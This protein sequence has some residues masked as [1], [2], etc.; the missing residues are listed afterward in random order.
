MCNQCGAC[1]SGLFTCMSMEEIQR[2]AYGYERWF[3]RRYWHEIPDEEG[4]RLAPWVASEAVTFF[5]CD[6]YD[7]KTKRCKWY[8]HRPNVCKDY[9]FYGEPVSSLNPDALPPG[10]GY[11]EDIQRAVGRED[12]KYRLKSIRYRGMVG[13]RKDRKMQ[14]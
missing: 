8:G 5:R 10:C 12:R 2:R 13:V 14:K 4:R 1:C 7:E 11:R 6:H 9:L 3:V